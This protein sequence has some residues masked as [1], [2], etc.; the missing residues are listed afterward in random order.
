MEDENKKKAI[1]KLQKKNLKEKK[2]TSTEDS[3]D[4]NILGSDDIQIISKGIDQYMQSSSFEKYLQNLGSAFGISNR[5]NQLSGNFIDLSG[6]NYSKQLEINGQINDLK[7]QL[8]EKSKEVDA[9]S[10]NEET[11]RAKINEL[12]KII[13]ELRGKES[14]S[15]ILTR[16][17]NDAQTLLFEDEKFKEK[18]N[19]GENSETVVVSIDIRRSTELML[20]ARKPELFASFITTLSRQLSN[21]IIKNYGIFDK[22]TGDG[23]LAFFPKFYSGENAMLRALIAAEECHQ[24]FNQHYNNSRECFNVFIKDVGLGIGVDYGKVTL[25][26]NGN[27]LTVVGIPVVYACRMSS[28]KAGQT[29]LNQPAKEEISRIGNDSIKII[30]TEIFIKNEGTALAY[31]VELTESLKKISNPDWSSNEQN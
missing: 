4:S 26:N 6:T 13:F 27:E 31:E 3:A 18:F 15:H 7:R 14:I 24:I 21:A 28:A 1:N 22:F 10:S 16:V 12:D 5:V 9:A 17:H 2:I 23:I 8:L 19:D 11:H 20:K 29:L 25:V 30:E